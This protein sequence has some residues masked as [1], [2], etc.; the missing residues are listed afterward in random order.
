[1]AGMLGTKNTSHRRELFSVVGP[2]LEVLLSDCPCFKRACSARTGHVEAVTRP[3]P[4]VVDRNSRLEVIIAFADRISL[5]RFLAA[6]NDLAQA[7]STRSLDSEHRLAD[8]I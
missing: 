1:M 5:L 2:E 8:V 4:T 6:A 7:R 3:I